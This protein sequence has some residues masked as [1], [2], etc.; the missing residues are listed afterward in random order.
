MLEKICAKEIVSNC[1]LRSDHE[2]YTGRG[3]TL[4]DLT[5]AKLE[6]IYQQI[7]QRCGNDA[8]YNFVKMIVDIPVLSA[9]DFLLT[10]Y[11]LEK[12]KW[13]WNQKLLTKEQRNHVGGQETTLQLITG[14]NG[15][16]E[17]KD[18]RKWFLK[19][20]KIMLAEDWNMRE[21]WGLK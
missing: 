19:D 11:R 20:H 18:I 7:E 5:S 13:I 1:G 17:T 9:T 16:D 14:S 21:S 6:D 8:S 2:F 12:N 3:A 15:L 4:L 10:L